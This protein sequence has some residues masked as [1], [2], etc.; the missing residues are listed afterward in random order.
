MYYL[1]ILGRSLLIKIYYNVHKQIH[2]FTVFARLNDYYY[3]LN[4][5]G[6]NNYL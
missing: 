1:L 2:F 5:Y 6:E 3:L 4:K